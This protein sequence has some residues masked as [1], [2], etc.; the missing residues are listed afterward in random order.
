MVDFSIDADFQKDL[1]WARAFVNEKVMPLQYLFDYDMDA[2]FD[3]RN[4][5][6]RHI[7]ER[8]QEE[9]KTRGLWA[10]HLPKHLGGP[11]LGAVKLTYLNEI[12]GKTYFASVV[13]G[14]QGPDTGN[15]EILAMFGTE[16][17][18]ARY[19]QPLMEGKIFSAYAM[20]EPQ[21]GSDPTS[22][23][24]TAT[25]DADDW[26]ING[27][28]W[29]ASSA[30][31]AAFTIVCA[32]TNP[33]APERHKRMTMFIVPTDTPG[34]EVVREIGFFVDP[35]RRGGHPWVRYNNV[36]VPDSARLGPLNEGFKVAQSRLGGGRLHHAQRTIGFCQYMLDMMGERALSRSS[37]GK[38][39]SE[40]QQVQFDL[41]RSHIEL[42]QFRLLVLYTAW[43]FDHRKEH[44]PE[45]RAA[46][47]AVKA[48]M[49]KV[50]EDI[51][52]RCL[53]LHASIGLSNAMQLGRWLAI[54]LHE[55]VADG[56]TEVHLTAVAKQLLKGYKP[57]KGPFPTEVIWERKAWAAE[58]VQPYLDEI[59]ATL[60]DAK[61]TRS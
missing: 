42:Q 11:G 52:L 46:I 17:Q 36:R 48:A 4:K 61:G 34:F 54:A 3:I 56:V 13:F 20:T 2:P 58:R 37:F 39:I 12:F 26:I 44:G 22:F 31:H 53:H 10:M 19:L 40:H 33:Q 50:A 5:P 24:T 43:L 49:A 59:G 60:E 7:I 16:E 29:F 1:D 38:V 25:R 15:A 18:K 14:C 51:G 6:L 55:G 21:G 47:A 57:S 8:L 30:N 23:K 27:D 28:K 32:Q 45:G 41:A 35:P 9:V